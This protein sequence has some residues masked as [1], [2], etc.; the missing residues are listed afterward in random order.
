M[1]M[2]E[3]KGL[4][5]GVLGVIEDEFAGLPVGGLPL[6]SPH[7]KALQARVQSFLL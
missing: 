5:F 3:E 1:V 6:W 2:I 4:E 7:L